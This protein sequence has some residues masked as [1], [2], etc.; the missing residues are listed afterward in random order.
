MSDNEIKEIQ[1]LFVNQVNE[2]KGRNF[3]VLEWGGGHS[4][5]YFVNFFN[6]FKGINLT[7]DVVEHSKDW[8]ELMKS[9]KLSNV[10]LHK[11]IVNCSKND[12]VKHPMNKYV[13]LPKTLNK[14]WDVIIVDGRKRRRCL[15]EAKDLLKENG[16]IILHDAQRDYYH[17]AFEYF[18]G[19]FITEVD[20]FNGSRIWIGKK[21]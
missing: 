4:T 17:S 9:W 18:D 1:K 15:I 19:K 14:K 3:D 21:K 20:K 6:F 11:A 16:I 10:N 8:Y 7:W 12:L 2:T 13:N 5:M